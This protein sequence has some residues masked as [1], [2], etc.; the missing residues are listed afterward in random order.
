MRNGNKHS[1]FKILL[2]L[3]PILITSACGVDDSAKEQNSSDNSTDLNTS[4]QIDNNYLLPERLLKSGK[5]VVGVVPQFQPM[6]FYPEGTGEL[7]G[8]D[9][10][11]MT[12]IAEK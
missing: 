1:G 3:L 6:A 12:A 2:I 10:E 8:S 11:M 4:S 9:P 5:I 7:A